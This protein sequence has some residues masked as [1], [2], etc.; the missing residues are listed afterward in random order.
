M[1]VCYAAIRRNMPANYWPK[2]G[3][4]TLQVP[5]DTSYYDGTVLY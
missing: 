2:V 3:H 5:L 4:V 1:F